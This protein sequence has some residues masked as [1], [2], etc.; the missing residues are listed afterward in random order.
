[1]KIKSNFDIFESAL[2]MKSGSMPLNMKITLLNNH[3]YDAD[4]SNWLKH[5]SYPCDMSNFN[6]S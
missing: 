6:L 3:D 2:Y 5:F 4:N 1:M